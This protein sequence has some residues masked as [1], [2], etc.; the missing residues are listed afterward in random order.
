M[1][2]V[3]VEY[4]IHYDSREHARN[5][6][7]RKKSLVEAMEGRLETLQQEVQSTLSLKLGNRSS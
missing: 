5:S 7:L 3:F 2:F 6:R 1:I 4:V